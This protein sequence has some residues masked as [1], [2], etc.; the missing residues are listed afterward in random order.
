MTI[1]STGV[2]PPWW[3]RWRMIQGRGEM[4]GDKKE[5]DKEMEGV[6]GRK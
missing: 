2:T 4:E 5:G 1:E 3:E 6:D